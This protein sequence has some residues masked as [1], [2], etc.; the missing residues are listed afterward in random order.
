[1]K[2]LFLRILYL[3]RDRNFLKI[4]HITENIV[5]KVL[6][7]A[8]IIVIFVALIEL[9]VTLFAD[10]RQTEPV[11]FFNKTLLEIFGL[12]LNILIALELLEN[13][14]AYLRKHIVQLELVLTTALI[15]LARKII[16]FDP[17]LYD[18]TDLISLGFTTLAISASYGLVRYLN[19]KNR[20]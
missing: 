4:I 10:I 3:L 19:L 17:K 20:N 5:S 9:T 7:L 11:G 13:I 6:S 12:F 8:L 14:T 16:I 1:M 18:K 2:K 15:A